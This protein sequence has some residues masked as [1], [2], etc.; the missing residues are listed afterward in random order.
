MKTKIPFLCPEGRARIAHASEKQNYAVILSKYFVRQ[1]DTRKCQMADTLPWYTHI[2]PFNYCACVSLVLLLLLILSFVG[3][4]ACRAPRYAQIY[5]KWRTL[6]DF[7]L[8]EYSDIW[9]PSTNMQCWIYALLVCP[10]TAPISNSLW[11]RNMI[12]AHSPHW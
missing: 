2:C 10:Q 12:V 6:K 7:S 9:L 8:T 1:L 11:L 5:S 3:T 4:V